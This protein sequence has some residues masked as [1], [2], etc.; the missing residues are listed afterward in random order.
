QDA[1]G[2][3]QNAPGAAEEAPSVSEHVSAIDARLDA[4][5]A[6]DD[7]PEGGALSDEQVNR[8]AE[9]VTDGLWNDQKFTAGLARDFEA[10]HKVA[11]LIYARF[12]DPANNDKK[13]FR[14]QTLKMSFLNLLLTFKDDLLL[15]KANSNLYAMLAD[16]VETVDGDNPNPRD[17][18]DHKSITE[19]FEDLSEGGVKE[20]LDALEIA[21][22]NSRRNLVSYIGEILG[23]KYLFDKVAGDPEAEVIVFVGGA[24]DFLTWLKE[25]ALT[26]NRGRGLF[27]L[28]KWQ[29][30]NGASEGALAPGVIYFA[31]C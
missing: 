9:E 30:A 21:G 16:M 26:E 1:A 29:A 19:Y 13:E 3:V 8:V 5:F 24:D 12:T 2:P 10:F 6:G 17:F 15:G 7:A 28:G 18:T 22:I 11:H 4:L 14:R 25:D 31:D 20:L 23:V 27:R